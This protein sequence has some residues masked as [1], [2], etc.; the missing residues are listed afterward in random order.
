MYKKDTI[1]KAFVKGNYFYLVDTTNGIEYKSHTKDI[2]ITPKREDSNKYFIYNLKD[3]DNSTSIDI[4]NIKDESD[5]TYTKESFENFYTAFTGT[6]DISEI[7]TKD[8]LNSLIELE[9]PLHD[10]IDI[11]Y[12]TNED[13]QTVKYSLNSDV[14]L[15]LTLSY[16]SNF[17]LTNVSKS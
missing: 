1:Y 15:T 6:I 17:N 4:S 8:A 2:L 9:V 12:N 11:T 5:S 13:I 7:A 3:W 16:D 10:N 14:V